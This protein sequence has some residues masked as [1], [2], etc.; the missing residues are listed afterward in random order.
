MPSF[1]RNKRLIIILI[2]FILLVSL[3]GVSM[4]DRENLT[5][6]EQV[7]M[8]SVGW[9]QT[10]FNQPVLLVKEVSENIRDMKDTYDENQ[11]LKSKLTEYRS[12]IVEVQELREENE[13]LR[14]I[15]GKEESLRNYK[16]IQATVIARSPESWFDQLTINKGKLHGVEKNMAVITGD[17]MVGKVQSA[18]QGK[19]TVKLLSGFDRSNRISAVISGEEGNI[20]G[21]IE[22]YDDD[23]EAL[24]LVIK[25]G[26]YEEDIKEGQM[27]SSSG[28]G[29]V[30]PSGLFIGTIMEV[31]IDEYGLTE[32]AY[33]KPAANLYDMNHV[34]VVDREMEIAD[35][36]AEEILE[37]EGEEE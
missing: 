2:S 13:E 27:V 11:I 15:V 7:I 1:F 28:M 23:K 30:F 6:P 14:N 33:V 25:R 22:G 21:L 9:L 19:A 32:N 3:I 17:G 34:M 24:L 16:P 31:S 18:S 29:G 10:L 37:G 12:L 4:R 5:I 8:D 26:S 35:P 36:N 20:Y